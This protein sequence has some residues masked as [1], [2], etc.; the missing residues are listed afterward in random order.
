MPFSVGTWLSLGNVAAALKPQR[1]TLADG[2]TIDLK[3][4][5]G[6]ETGQQMRLKGKGQAGPG[7]AGDG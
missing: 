6:L 3:L 4:P 1:I 7:G 2:K 5:A